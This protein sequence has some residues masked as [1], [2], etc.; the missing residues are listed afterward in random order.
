MVGLAAV[1]LAIVLVGLWVQTR[2]LSRALG[3]YRSLV[4]DAQGSS[5][6]DVLKSHLARV[7][8]VATRLD[9]LVVLAEH[10]EL[11]SRGSLQHVGLVRFNPFDDTGSDQ[12]FAI[13]LLDQRR[14]GIVISSL[15]GRGSTR[16]FAKPVEGGES[17]HTLS[18][19]EAEAIRIAL[20]GTRP[21]PVVS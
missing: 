1:L 20:E 6:A 15:H 11:R 13:A 10:L 14:D 21:V 9:D 17:K 5:L 19:E 12:S 4:G 18:G 7:D 16:L 8:Q 2:R 3:A